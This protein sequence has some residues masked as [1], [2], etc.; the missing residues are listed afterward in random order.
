M[1]IHIKADLDELDQISTAPAH[2]A[3]MR[4]IRTRRYNPPE[5]RLVE[6]GQAILSRI[7]NMN[8]DANCN[9]V[10]TGT[11]TDF[12]RATRLSQATESTGK[13]NTKGVL[14]DQPE[15]LIPL[16]DNPVMSVPPVPSP[17]IPNIAL[18][19]QDIPQDTPLP[20][21][22]AGQPLLD[23]PEGI[24]PVDQQ[25]VDRLRLTLREMQNKTCPACLEYGFQLQGDVIAYQFA[26]NGSL[27]EQQYTKDLR[28][29]MEGLE[30]IGDSRALPS[31]QEIREKWNLKMLRDNLNKAIDRILTCSRKAVCE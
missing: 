4:R 9:F 27:A 29:S 5:A 17:V 15:N 26:L 7:E 11:W 18:P 14:E 23:F 8:M 12:I 30:G 13:A 2:H 31:E 28:Q 20:F 24:D 21:D 1:I 19:P 25:V 16:P 6:Q 22:T 3:V 10:A